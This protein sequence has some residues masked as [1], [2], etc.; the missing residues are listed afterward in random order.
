MEQPKS[1]VA[2]T[3]SFDDNITVTMQH[4]LLNE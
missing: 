4:Q 1:G 2:I 3:K